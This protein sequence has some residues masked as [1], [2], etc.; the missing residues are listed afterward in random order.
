MLDNSHITVGLKPDES[1]FPPWDKETL[2]VVALG[3]GVLEVLQAP[4]F[5]PLLRNHDIVPGVVFE[6]QWFAD[7]VIEL[8][9]HSTVRVVG[10]QNKFS[11]IAHTGSSQT[12]HR[13]APGR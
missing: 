10:F 1:S 11:K 5:V 6:P 4:V 2:S 13:S 3:G 7:H 12:Q 9:G 8:R